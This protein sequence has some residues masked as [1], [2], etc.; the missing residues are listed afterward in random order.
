M[1]TR[2][3]GVEFYV[4]QSKEADK[5]AARDLAKE[6][7][8]YV[9]PSGIRSGET[10]KTYAKQIAAYAEW[11]AKNTIAK[12]WEQAKIFVH[13]YLQGM[14]DGTLLTQYGKRYS[15]WSIHTVAFALGWSGICCRTFD[16]DLGLFYVAYEQ[17]RQ[18]FLVV[19]YV[20]C[21]YLVYLVTGTK[22]A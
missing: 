2:S 19:V 10:M 11:V 4:G 8:V 15:P 22:T 14:V 18:R 9:Q 13:Q 3:R 6:T 7:G 16:W 5:K 20:S 1:H 21:L 12:N 17:R